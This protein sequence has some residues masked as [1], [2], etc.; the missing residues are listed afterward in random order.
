M[1]GCFPLCF[2]LSVIIGLRL[3]SFETRTSEND[4]EENIF[5]QLIWRFDI[6]NVESRRTN[7]IIIYGGK[8]NFSQVFK[9]LGGSAY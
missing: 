3:L 4:P 5:A 2:V 6:R 8:S 7:I 1:Y 9:V